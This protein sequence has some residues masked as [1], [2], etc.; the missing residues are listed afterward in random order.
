M[1]WI[2]LQIL[3]WHPYKVKMLGLDL[4]IIFLIFRPEKVKIIGFSSPSAPKI[5]KKKI[6]WRFFFKGNK[7]NFLTISQTAFQWQFVKFWNL[8]FYGFHAYSFYFTVKR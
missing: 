1:N 4:N 8:I 2:T 6:G 5:V 7:I 3:N